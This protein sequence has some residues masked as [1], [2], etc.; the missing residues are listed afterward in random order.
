MPCLSTEL[1]RSAINKT[2]V[3]KNKKQQNKQKQKTIFTAKTQ[4]VNLKAPINN[5]KT[6]SDKILTAQIYVFIINKQMGLYLNETRQQF[7]T[8]K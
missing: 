4:H 5:I 1:T 8:K 2:T 7:E 3:E 6:Q